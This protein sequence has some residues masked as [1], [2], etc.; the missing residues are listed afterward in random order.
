ML[1]L[2]TLPESRSWLWSVRQSLI[3]SLVAGRGNLAQRKQIK[4]QRL[5]QPR[6]I[7]TWL[8]ETNQCPDGVWWDIRHHVILSN[9]WNITQLFNF[10]FFLLENLRV[11][12]RFPRQFRVNYRDGGD[13][14]IMCLVLILSRSTNDHPCTIL[15]QPN[16]VKLIKNDPLPPS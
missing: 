8:S 2:W 7:D 11:V 3:W 14:T 12:Q 16:L 5:Q 15:Y 6:Q 4:V 13:M 10:M 9:T 1:K